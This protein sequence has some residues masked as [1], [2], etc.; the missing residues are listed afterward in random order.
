MFDWFK[1]IFKKELVEVKIEPAVV[2]RKPS[3]K[4]ATTRPARKTAVKAKNAKP[5]KRTKS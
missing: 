1:K 2:K 5:V 3:V 4:K